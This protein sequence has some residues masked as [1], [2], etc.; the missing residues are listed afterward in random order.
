MK[1]AWIIL[2][3]ALLVVFSEAKRKH[4][5]EGDF[6]FAE[7]DETRTS[8][9]K[10]PEKKRWIHDPNSDLCQPLN[11]KKKDI[12]LLEDSFTAVCVSKKELHRSGDIVIPKS[13]LQ[14]QETQQLQQT[15]SQDEDIFYDSEDDSDDD[16]ADSAQDII[17]TRC[18]PCPVM[19]PTFLCGNDNHTYSSLCRLDYHNCV[20]RSSV[21]VFCKGFCPCKEGDIHMRKKQKQAERMNNFMNKYKATMMEQEKNPQAAADKYTFTPQDF[22]YENKHYKYIKY[23]KHDNK[24]SKDT[25]TATNPPYYEDKER[26]RGDNE[27][28]D[29]KPTLGSANS[30]VGGGSSGGGSSWTKECSPSALQAMGD[31]L[32]DWFSVIMADAKRRRTHTKGKG[33]RFPTGCKNEVRWMFEHLDSE[34]DGQLSLQELYDLEHD[35]NEHCIKPFLDACDTD[36]DIF[37]SPRE[38]CKCFDK[39]DRPCAAVKRRITS[40]IGKSKLFP[41][42]KKGMYVP[43]CDGDGYYRST[44]CHNSV[45]MCWCVDKHGVELPNS[46]TRG[47]PNCDALLMKSKTSSP[48]ISSIDAINDNDDDEND[49][50]DSDEDLE[51]SADQPLDF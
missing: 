6:E 40:A 24:I 21:K 22:K 29:T 15:H 8:N 19:K 50:E 1:F 42:Y 12:C 28:L 25:F 35:Q 2:S 51:G 49:D 20:H 46:R 38:W 13:K 16:E 44:Q 41:S 48:K 30:V 4:K 43:D 36:R 32:L 11:C 3:V 17:R 9:N 47:K 31:R 14:Q 27:V 10:M 26:L 7:E 23:T 5:F 45:G 33:N 39:T 34:P 18:T 37:I